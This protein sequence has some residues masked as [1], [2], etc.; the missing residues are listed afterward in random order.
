LPAG[1]GLA[2]VVALVFARI[3]G[4]LRVFYGARNRHERGR[5]VNRHPFYRGNRTDG[6]PSVRLCRHCVEL[7]LGLAQAR[8]VRHGAE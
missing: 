3:G 8:A 6:S 1:F 5:W 2:G 7:R 4:H